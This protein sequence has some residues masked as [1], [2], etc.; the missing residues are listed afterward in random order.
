MRHD[1]V[2]VTTRAD[3]INQSGQ[4]NF[5]C[6]AGEPLCFS[7]QVGVI[8]SSCHPGVNLIF[9]FTAP[10]EARCQ[11]VLCWVSLPRNRLRLRGVWSD[12]VPSPSQP[13]LVPGLAWPP[14]S[15]SPTSQH[16]LPAGGQPPLPHL[17]H[18]HERLQLRQPGGDDVLRLQQ[19]GL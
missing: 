12:G 16:L 5:S 1:N 13:H 6:G 19:P 3:D 8:L 9:P 15:T 17:Q 14:T 4:Y 2:I 18:Q 11:C 7:V 10:P